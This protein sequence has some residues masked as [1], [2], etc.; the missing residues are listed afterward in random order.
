MALVLVPL[1][2]E[3]AELVAEY[4]AV[5]EIATEATVAT[6]TSIAERDAEIEG[7]LNEELQP[8][9]ER[10]RAQMNRRRLAI[11]ARQAERA[12]RR[13]AG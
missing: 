3:I 12:A 6:E 8:Y 13:P 10:L 2:G 1:L 5:E 9:V 11:A 7:L 4:A